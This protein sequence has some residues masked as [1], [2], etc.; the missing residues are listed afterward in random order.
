MILA[1]EIYS[2]S[3][4]YYI[5]TARNKKLRFSILVA[6]PENSEISKLPQEAYRNGFLFADFDFG[7]EET[8]TANQIS[9]DDKMFSCVLVYAGVDG[10]DEYPVSF[11]CSLIV[12]IDGIDSIDSIDI[13]TSSVEKTESQE[14][15]NKVQE[16][17][18]HLRLVKS[19]EGN[20]N[21]I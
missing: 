7:A 15:L 8:W 13:E 12:G 11:P 16:S 18:K 20:T 10:W 14:F 4:S 21:E 6:V 19:W 3:I 9:I 1:D 2:N 17:K 5:E